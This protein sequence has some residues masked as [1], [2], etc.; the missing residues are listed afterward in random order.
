M[1]TTAQPATNK[2]SKLFRLIAGR[3]RFAGVLLLALFAGALAES[4]GL[5]LVLPLLNNLMGLEQANQGQFMMMLTGLLNLLPDGSRIEGLL[6]LFAIAFTI[7]GAL[8]VLNRALS[9]LFAYRLRQ[10]WAGQLLRH[11]LHADQAYLDDRPQGELI[12]NVVHETQIGAKVMTNIVEFANKLILS[13][14]L[15]GVLLAVNWQATIIVGA[16]TGIVLT[17]IRKGLAGYSLRFGKIRIRLA[18]QISVMATESLHNVRQI[19]LFGLY[20]QRHEIFHDYLRRFANAAAIFRAVSEIPKQMTELSVIVLLAGALFWVQKVA[21]QDVQSVAVLLGFFILIAQRLISNVT[22]LTSRRMIIGSA[23]P[24]LHMIYE[25]LMGA[26][27]RENIETGLKFK[28]LE[29]DIIFDDVA[30]SYG[31][32]RQVFSGLHLTISKGSTTALIGPSG[33]GKST[34]V[35]I[36]TGF[37]R[38]QRGHV[39]SNGQNLS[40]YSVESLRQH[41]GYLTQEPEIFDATVLENIRMGWPEA[42][43]EDC[44]AAAQKAHAHDFI[45]DLPKQYD[46]PVGDRGNTLSVGQRQRL[47]LARVIVR[48]P[49]LYIFDEPTSALDQESERLVR[50]SMKALEG[51]ATVIIIAH[52][53][54]TI[55]HADAIY[56]IGAQVQQIRMAEVDEG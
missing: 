30:F 15:F 56:R 27:N 10:D 26:P 22:Y 19:K 2:F 35:D 38:P 39:T 7:K 12:Q 24:S 45:A 9:A 21:E 41:I 8:L 29:S 49:D 52:Q 44:I 33:A 23:L 1:K 48:K 28:G 17:L 6:V 20:G 53:L 31:D 37:R 16:V 14:M 18:R 55:D 42:T 40:D 3:E 43:G 32:G 34:L 11:Y 46:T 47:A 50:D 13:V 25:L 4:F 36:L 51:E 54:S 5:S